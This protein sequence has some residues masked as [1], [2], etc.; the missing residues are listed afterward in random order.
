MC[1]VRMSNILAKY[2]Y[3]HLFRLQN[4]YLAQVIGII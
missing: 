4:N 1:T 2:T 3:K